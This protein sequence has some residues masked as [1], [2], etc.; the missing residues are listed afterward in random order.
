MSAKNNRIEKSMGIKATTSQSQISK[1]LR[2]EVERH[3]RVLI[4]TMLYCAEE[5]T[6]AAR[7]T[8]S[9]KDQT[10][11][12]RSSVGSIVIVDGRVIQEY[13]FDTVK[14]GSQG[15][16]DG[17]EYAH[18]LARLF[19]TGIAV[20]VVAGKDYASYVADKGYDVLDSAEE[21]AKQI[22]TKSLNDLR[23]MRKSR[24]DQEKANK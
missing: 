21:L 6:N 16:T 8:D 9:Y 3:R 22:V 23:T 7:S 4:R 11:N 19:P 20:V 1:M 18:S 12:L 2:E 10:G 17:K 5:L 13:G 24:L 14:S 15:V